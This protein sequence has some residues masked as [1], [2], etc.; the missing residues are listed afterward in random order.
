VSKP[1]KPAQLQAALLQL[2]AGNTAPRTRTT[3][4]SKLDKNL[5]SRYPLRILLADDNPIN[6]KVATR[7]LQQFGF[8]ADIAN[9]GLAAIGALERQPY[10]IIFMDV[11]MPEL[12]G[13]ET[14]R[15]IRQRQQDPSAVAH[16]H[17]PIMIVAM[18]A[19]AMHG[20]REKC[21]AAGMDDYIPKPVRPEAIQELIERAGS[22]IFAPE[23]RAPSSPSS[24]SATPVAENIVPVDMARLSE[25]SGDME[26]GFRELVDLYLTQTTQQLEQL[27]VAVDNG[28]GE[29]VNRL[30]HSCAGAS[31]TCGMVAI[32]PLLRRLE[33]LGA[34]NSLADAPQVFLSVA[35]E[36]DRIRTFLQTHPKFLSAA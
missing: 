25:F 19:N 36:F 2:T 12:D 4:T 20:D 22:K 27:R 30:A 6:Q 31:A 35:A 8:K 11:Q 24:P 34:E 26:D 23:G 21:V 5:A 15:R 10:D 29:R 28:N 14:T 9:N 18:T 16:F 1:I 32:V 17:R 7:L 3:V 33:Q 13:L